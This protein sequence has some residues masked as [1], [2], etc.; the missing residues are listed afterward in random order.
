MNMPRFILKSVIVTGLIL[1]MAWIGGC[2]NTSDSK[3]SAFEKWKEMAEKSR[4]YSPR[5]R[6]RTI[7]LPSKKIETIAPHLADRQPPRPLPKPI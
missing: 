7:D 5:S 6:K 1:S 2:A 3:T 4:G